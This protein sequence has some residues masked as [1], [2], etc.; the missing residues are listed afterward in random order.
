[1]QDPAA[2]TVYSVKHA[3]VVINIGNLKFGFCWI[4]IDLGR[5]L[6]GQKK[7][8]SNTI[9]LNWFLIVFSHDV[10]RGKHRAGN[11]NFLRGT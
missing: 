7:L 11:K 8:S 6:A 2:V 5:K 4:T 3:C 1:V 10:G 9:V